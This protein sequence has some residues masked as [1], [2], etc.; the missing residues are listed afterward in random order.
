MNAS[1]TIL[2]ALVQSNS[3]IYPIKL[4]IAS[5]R[6]VWHKR[7]S[8]EMKLNDA[9]MK[10]VIL[11]TMIAY[12]SMFPSLCLSL[13]L[14]HTSTTQ[15]FRAKFN[16]TKNCNVFCSFRTQCCEWKNVYSSKR[17]LLNLFPSPVSPCFVV[18]ENF[19]ETGNICSWHVCR[20]EEM[21]RMKLRYTLTHVIFPCQTLR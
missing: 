3:K 7:E 2:C 6:A 13:S 1:T 11:F 5:I 14:F 20:T 4:T 16:E 10:Y 9:Y 8:L 12:L 15:M 21:Q 17:N 19:G 18:N